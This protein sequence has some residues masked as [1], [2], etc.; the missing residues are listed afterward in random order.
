MATAAATTEWQEVRRPQA[1]ANETRF[2]VQMVWDEYRVDTKAVP[3][4][5]LRRGVVT[6]CVSFEQKMEIHAIRDGEL[7]PGSEEVGKDGKLAWGKIIR[8]GGPECDRLLDIESKAEVKEGLREVTALR[9]F[10]REQFNDVN[11][12]GLLYGGLEKLPDLNEDLMAHLTARRE[13]LKA[14][15]LPPSVP[16]HLHS[17]VWKAIDEV[18][19]ALE[20]GSR[21]QLN[22]IEF[23][24]QRRRLQ[25]KDEA[26][27]FKKEYDA[28]DEE[29]LKRTGKPRFDDAADQTATALKTLAGLQ[30]AGPQVVVQQDNAEM[31]T[32]LRQ[33]VENQN[34]LIEAL[35]KNQPQAE[36][37]KP[38]GPKPEA[39]K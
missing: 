7:I 34:K 1:N 26:G 38:Q 36:R 19:A 12:N 32:L 24:H 14:K 17:N 18:I 2:L 39:Q 37:P 6:P 9:G 27:L 13:E 29:M 25:P 16:A 5:A 35:L 3:G 31:L 23:T 11:I 33:Q 28:K 20:E 21:I 30:G 4:K 8:P 15:G 22:R 10:T